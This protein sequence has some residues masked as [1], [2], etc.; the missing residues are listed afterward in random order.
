[1]ACANTGR[2]ECA[3]AAFEA[4]IRLN[5]RDASAYTNLGLFHLEGA[6]AAAAADYFAEA[7][8]L[9]PGSAAARDGL[10]QVRAAA[11]AR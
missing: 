6:N 7:L 8:A 1:L 3:Q 5:P 10:R 11:G 4:S 9:D 2:R